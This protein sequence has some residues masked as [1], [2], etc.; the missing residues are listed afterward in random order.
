MNDAVLGKTIE[1]VRKHRNI[2]LAITETK[3][4]CLV[5]GINYHTTKFFRE[6]LLA[7]QMKKT[8]ILMSKPVYLGL[9]I[10][11]LSKILMCKFCY[12]YLK[13]RYGDQIMLYGYI[14]SYI[15]F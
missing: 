12:D 3:R 2:E 5:S 6:N 8:Q 11:E 13:P 15:L 9:P 14:I 10:L 7:M 4:N 1:N